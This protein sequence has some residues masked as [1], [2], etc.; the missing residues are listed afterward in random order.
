V[1]DFYKTQTLLAFGF[2]LTAL[3]FKLTL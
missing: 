3:R 2:R 1:I